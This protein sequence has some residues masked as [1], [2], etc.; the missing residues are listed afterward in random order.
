MGLGRERKNEKILR[1][2]NF[3]IK[4][5]NFDLK[6]ICSKKNSGNERQWCTKTA[7]SP[8]QMGHGKMGHFKELLINLL[9]HRWWDWLPRR[10]TDHC[11]WLAGGGTI[12]FWIRQTCGGRL[13]NGNWH[14]FRWILLKLIQ[15]TIL[16]F[17]WF[18]SGFSTQMCGDN[19]E[20]SGAWTAA[21]QTG[22]WSR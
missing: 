10:W 14:N 19:S 15:K 21:N 7:S 12:T 9:L 22:T 11:R 1:C 3:Q 13:G 16:W 20:R 6:I 2:P 8:R 18:Y 5:D 4:I 17:W